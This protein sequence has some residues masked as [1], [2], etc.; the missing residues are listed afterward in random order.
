MT[1]KQPN[2]FSKVKPTLDTLQD[3]SSSLLVDLSGDGSS[4]MQEQKRYY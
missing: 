1:S 3:T 2:K 4:M